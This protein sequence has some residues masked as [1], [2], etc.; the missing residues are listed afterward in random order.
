M[1]AL[2][3][4]APTLDALRQHVLG[5]GTNLAW[6]DKML[7]PVEDLPVVPDRAAYL[8]AGTLERVTRTAIHGKR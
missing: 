8:V 4:P 7:Q 2:R 5:R 6:A 3:E 1:P